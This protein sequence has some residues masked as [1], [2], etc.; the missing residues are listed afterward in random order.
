MLVGGRAPRLLFGCL[1]GFCLASFLHCLDASYHPGLRSYNYYLLPTR[2]WEL[3]AGA[4]LAMLPVAPARTPRWI[5][6][7]T[8]AFALAAI[9]AAAL[10][11]TRWTRFPGLLALVPVLGTALFIYASSQ[12]AILVACIL[13]VKPLAI[14]GASSYS[15][16]LWHWPILV[17]MRILL[18]MQDLPMAFGV[19]A[20]LVSVL[21]GY[22]SWALI[23]EPIRRRQWLADNTR[24]V[25][26]AVTCVIGLVLI[27]ATTLTRWSLLPYRPDTFDLSVRLLHPTRPKEGG[28][29]LLWGDSHAQSLEGLFKRLA[30]EN[31]Q[32]VY[33]SAAGAIAPLLG[34]HNNLTVIMEVGAQRS[35][36]KQVVDFALRHKVKH[37]ILC[38]SWQNR[39][40]LRKGRY[41]SDAA[42]IEGL[43]GDEETPIPT[44][45]QS[46]Q[47][48][49]NGLLRTH[50]TLQAAGIKLWF[51]RPVPILPQSVPD[52]IAI[53]K[54][55]KV[56]ARGI[57]RMDFEEQQRPINQ[58]LAELQLPG[59]QILGPTPEWFDQDGYT[60]IEGGDMAF[61]RDDNHLTTAG[62]ENYYRRLVQP[63]FEE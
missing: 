29:I 61:Y 9:F 26:V 24:L 6:E 8:A 59:V 10:L 52:M 25:V 1:L 2:A 38:C 18:Q 50:Q 33:L 12:R 16:Y 62:A 35:W 53:A 60:R 55:Q 37:V 45:A 40:G 7:L 63:I 36:N 28:Q 42:I 30:T 46:R 34:V 27:S 58:L 48:F 54:G 11:Y 23:E 22:I 31:D 43:I 41:P 56:P 32:Q 5:C 44:A 21:V 20:F 51:L 57:S 3:L 4:V 13:S 39:L 17:F 15:I 14:I 47:V 19:A 49:R